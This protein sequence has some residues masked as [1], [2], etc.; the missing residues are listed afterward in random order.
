M[1]ERRALCPVRGTH[2]ASLRVTRLEARGWREAQRPCVGLP[3]LP[4]PPGPAPCPGPASRTEPGAGAPRLPIM[5]RMLWWLEM[6]TQ[7]WSTSSFWRPLTSKRRPYRYLKDRMNQ[8]MIL[9]GE[10]GAGE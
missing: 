4:A 2:T 9:R 10:H 5:S 1:G 6:M 7:G 3:H 8:L